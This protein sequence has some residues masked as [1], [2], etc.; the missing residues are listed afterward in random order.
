MN[1]YEERQ[2]HEVYDDWEDIMEE[3]AEYNWS[4]PVPRSKVMKVAPERK[5]KNKKKSKKT[6]VGEPRVSVSAASGS[7]EL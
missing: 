7:V 1:Y 6:Q 4:V 2:K 5:P 3:E